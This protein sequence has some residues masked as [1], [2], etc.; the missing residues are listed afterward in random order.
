MKI[1]YQ[2]DDVLVTSFATGEG[3]MCTVGTVGT[4]AIFGYFYRQ[5]GRV[6]DLSRT[7]DGFGTIC[8]KD[9]KLH[10]TTIFTYEDL[11]RIL[12]LP[13]EAAK[14]KFTGTPPR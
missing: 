3:V 13:S 4:K 14:S 2:H 8:L 5:D 9:G 10:H 11:A 6:Q 12:G 1:F 7:N